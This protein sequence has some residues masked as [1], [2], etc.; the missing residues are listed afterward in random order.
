[1]RRQV[2]RLAPPASRWAPRLEGEADETAN[3]YGRP[4][5][6]RSVGSPRSTPAAPARRH[7]WPPA[8]LVVGVLSLV[9]GIGLGYGWAPRSGPATPSLEPAKPSLLAA[10]PSSDRESPTPRP[11]GPILV[12]PPEIPPAGG[13][14]LEK[15]LAALRASSA[16]QS[17][18]EVMGVQVTRFSEVASSGAAP[19][20]QWVWVF[21]VRTWLATGGGGGWVDPSLCGSPSPAASARAAAGS[22]SGSSVGC[23]SAETLRPVSVTRLVILDY[24]D[25]SVI[26][27]RF[28]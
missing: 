24:A 16:E 7:R 5:V 18:G 17:P 9:L 19:S 15:A 21:T 3:P 22:P 1:V 27:S 2:E 4:I 28:L 12:G 8:L 26:L 20:G 25:G 11:A 13:L 6:G 14:T 23:G 10:A